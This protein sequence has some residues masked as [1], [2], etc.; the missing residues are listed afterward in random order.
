MMPKS[1]KDRYIAALIERGHCLVTSKT[2]K[3]T[4]LTRASDGEGR[5]TFYFVG[6]SGALRAG[7][8]VTESIPVSDRFKEAL[9]GAEKTS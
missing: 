4:T 3:Y 1:L 5:M 8:T 6:R 2:G 7:R 9:L